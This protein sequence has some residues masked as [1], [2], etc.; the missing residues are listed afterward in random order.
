M[1]VKNEDGRRGIFW[2]EAFL[3]LFML[4]LG[5]CVLPR[6]KTFFSRKTQ[7]DWVGAILSTAGLALLTYIL[8]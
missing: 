7:L 4:V 8:A 6:D 1:Q 3:A 2:I 5:F